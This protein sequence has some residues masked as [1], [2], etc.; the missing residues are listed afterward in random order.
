MQPWSCWAVGQRGQGTVQ[1][2]PNFH[3]SLQWGKSESYK[4]LLLLLASS[5]KIN[6]LYCYSLFIYIYVFIDVQHMEFHF[7]F[8]YHLAF[9]AMIF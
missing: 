6:N 8:Y 1:R 3:Q 4:L 5:N 2:D 9:N 7:I